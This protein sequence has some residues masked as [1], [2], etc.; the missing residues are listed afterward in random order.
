MVIDRIKSFV[1]FSLLFVSLG[2]DNQTSGGTSG[3]EEEEGE[4]GIN[5]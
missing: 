5:Q 4:Q 3:S 2:N 1:L